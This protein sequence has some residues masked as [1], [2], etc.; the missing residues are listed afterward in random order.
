MDLYLEAKNVTVLHVP[1]SLD[2]GPCIERLY[3]LNSECTQLGV[4]SVED[5]VAA[6]RVV[7]GT[8]TPGQPRRVEGVD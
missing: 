4:A 5:A 1:I 8:P 7:A 3:T 6:A 2:S